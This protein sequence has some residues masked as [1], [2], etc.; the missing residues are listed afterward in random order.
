MLPRLGWCCRCNDDVH[1]VLEVLEEPV[2]TADVKRG[3]SGSAEQVV[4]G[5]ELL[6]VWGRAG[7]VRAHG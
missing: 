2:G 6:G 4:N 3:N 1:D 7:P 5:I